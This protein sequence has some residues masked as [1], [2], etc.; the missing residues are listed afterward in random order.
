VAIT[1]PLAANLLIAPLLAASVTALMVAF[2][3]DETSMRTQN[4]ATIVA[5]AVLAYPLLLVSYA[6]EETQ[7]Y[8]LAPAIYVG[9]VLVM[10]PLLPLKP[11]GRFAQAS[12]AAL[13][14]GWIWIALAP[15]YSEWRPQ[16]LSLYYVLDQDER[17]ARWAAI[18]A[19]PVPERIIRAFGTDPVDDYIVPW[20]STRQF[21]TFPAPALTLAKPNVTL[22]RT[23]SQ[24]VLKFRSNSGGD[25]MQLVLPAS[26]GISN[27]TVAGREVASV[28]RDGLIYVRYFAPGDEELEISFSVASQESFEGYVVDGRHTLPDIAGP[29]S[30][31]RGKLAVPQ[32]QGDQQL[33]FSRIQFPR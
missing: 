27:L 11:G 30:A 15:L 10:L 24:I 18:S 23:G 9:L 1:A 13:F 5:A 2:A 20:S 29:Y 32:H 6:M 31:A 17:E 3:L 14:I 4:V 25:F 21:P 26:A 12:A 33:A 28:E 22:E 8:R 16:H 19:N 7:G